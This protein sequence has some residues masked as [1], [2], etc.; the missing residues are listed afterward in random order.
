VEGRL[1]ELNLEGNRWFRDGYLRSR[2]LRAAHTPLDVA[3]LERELELLQQDPRI[4][5]A[6]AELLPADRPGD[7]HLRLAFHE[8]LPLSASHESS[9]DASPSIGQYRLQLDLAA[10]NRTGWGDTLRLMGAW[11]EG[12]WDGEAGYE[13]P[14]TV[15]DTTVGGWFRY[16][17]SDVIEEP[18]GG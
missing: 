18:F 4:G 1:T 5:Q 17:T 16:G 14:V 7:A 8:A 9:H 13:I 3:D 15:W 2:I 12:L 6:Q 11:T 10:R